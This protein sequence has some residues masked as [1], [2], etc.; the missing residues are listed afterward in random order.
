M[1]ERNPAPG[2]ID[3]KERGFVLLPRRILVR[4]SPQRDYLFLPALLSDNSGIIRRHAKYG[5][6]L[7]VPLEKSAISANQGYSGKW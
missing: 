1:A 5:Q 6:Q 2:A 7:F 4:Q 3:G